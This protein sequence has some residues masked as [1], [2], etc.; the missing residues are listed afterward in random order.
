MGARNRVYSVRWMDEKE[1]T[2]QNDACRRYHMG[3]IRHYDVD[4]GKTRRE[5]R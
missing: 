1:K 2:R 5:N 3:K 4:Y